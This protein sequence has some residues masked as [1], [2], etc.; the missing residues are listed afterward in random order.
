MTRVATPEY[1]I[2]I[3]WDAEDWSAD[4]GGDPETDDNISADVYYT[5]AS[6][7]KEKEEGNAPASFLQIKLKAGLHSNYSPFNHPDLRIWLPVRVRARYNAVWHPLFFGYIS[8]IRIDPSPNRQSV[9]IYI[10]DGMDLLARQVLRQD[11]NT[12][13]K[14]NPGGAINYIANAAGWSPNRRRINRT[15]TANLNYP[16]TGAY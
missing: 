10:T 15:E 6:R 5:D 7:G 1:E 8:A 16:S 2:V 3:D 11:Y 4:F 9:T 13:H 14:M 12:R